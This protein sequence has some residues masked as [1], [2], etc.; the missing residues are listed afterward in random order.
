MK[1]SGPGWSAAPWALGLLQLRE[2]PQYRRI[3]IER[4]AALVETALED[5]RSLADRTRDLWGSDPMNIAARCNVPVIHSENEAGFGSTIVHA[6]YR[7]RSPS[8]TLYLP[9]IRRL[10]RLVSEQ[11][12]QDRLG[13]HRTAP[14]FLAHELYHHFDCTHGSAPLSRR[15]R[16]RLFSIGPW[17]WTSGLSSLSEIAAGAFAQRLLGLSFHPKLL[18][19]L[20]AHDGSQAG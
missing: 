4:R 20:L 3:P 2:D 13:I 19:L 14:V 18:D 8:I 5:G 10:D 16:V 7:T 1:D 6:E 12:A 9:A 17:S 15:H 11:G